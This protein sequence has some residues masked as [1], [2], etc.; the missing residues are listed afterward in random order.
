[1]DMYS[2]TADLIDK[3][4]LLPH[5]EGGYYRR[6][7]TAASDHGERPSLTAIH[8]LLSEGQ[9]SAWH[10][11]DADEVWHFAEGEPLELFVYYPAEARLERRRLGAINDGC[12][13]MHV[14]PA[15]TWQ[16]ARPLGKYSLMTC[17]VAPG[18]EF[19]GF[20]LLQQDDPLASKLFGV[21]D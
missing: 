3:L 2:R 20:R 21:M 1:M 19:A 16:A 15:H 8:Y 18:F 4:D 17:I 7:H 13:P 14:V 6:L 5:V 9:R 12:S 11:V 10:M